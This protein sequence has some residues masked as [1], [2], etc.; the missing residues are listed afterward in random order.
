MLNEL[1]N[2]GIV[3]VND[4]VSGAKNRT[5]CVIGLPRSGTSMISSI[6]HNLEI[7]MGDDARAPTFEDGLLKRVFD[8]KDDVAFSDIAKRYD[9]KHEMWG[10]KLP[11]ATYDV[12]RAIASVRNPALIVVFREPLSVQIRKNISQKNQNI[13]DGM[14]DSFEA[15]IKLISD[16]KNLD[17]PMLLVSYDKVAGK[18]KMV[19]DEIADF[20]GITS[21]ELKAKALNLVDSDKEVYLDQARFDKT[22]G[23]VESV[24]G[25]II[26]GWAIFQ[27]PK[28]GSILEIE[29]LSGNNVVDVIRADIER[30]DLLATSKESLAKYNV[31]PIY[32]KRNLKFF[33]MKIGFEL[34]MNR[35]SKTGDFSLRVKTDRLPFFH[36]GDEI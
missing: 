17:V 13:F 3:R 21:D 10:F 2:N 28:P 35:Y 7:F 9:A 20:C 8:L 5:I 22:Y 12:S 25:G 11:R 33:D 14:K 24:E 29:V 1:E 36:C 19:I 34:N 32:L 4:D 27:L 18:S 16:L 6:M 31:N 15:Y 30:N 26:R 23:V